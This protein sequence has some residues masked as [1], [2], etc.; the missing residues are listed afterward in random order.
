MPPARGTRIFQNEDY[1]RKGVSP[2]WPMRN[3]RKE[4][5]PSISCKVRPSER[6]SHPK[7]LL[8]PMGWSKER[9]KRREHY[10][11]PSARKE[12]V[13]AREPGSLTR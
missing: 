12:L 4:E 5:Y 3:P 6:I 10:G 2:E 8:R 1:C 13:T 7:E 9:G 11:K